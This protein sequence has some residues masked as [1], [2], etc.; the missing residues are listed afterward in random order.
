MRIFIAALLMGSLLWPTTTHAQTADDILNIL[1]RK[2]T[3][4]QQEAESFRRVSVDGQ[5]LNAPA[6]DSFPLRLGRSLSLSGY[7]QVG[8]Q[9]FQHP[10]LGKYSDG[11]YIKRARLD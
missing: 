11:F 1:T 2:G 3:L 9:V 4:T 10:V 7:T 8:Y 6:S 5:H